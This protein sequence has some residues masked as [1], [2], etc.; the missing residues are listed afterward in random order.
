MSTAYYTHS[1]C[2]LH[3]MG[4]GHPECPRRL[5]AINDQLLSSGLD[6]A[7]MRMDA[8]LATLEQ[9]ERAHSTGYVIQL[10]DFLEQLQSSGESRHLD[11]DTVACPSTWRAAL[12]AAGAAVAATEA[13]VRGDVANAFCAVR[14]PGH[15]ATRD[16]TMGF[17]FFNNVAIAARHALDVL[18]LRRVAIVDFDVHHGNGTEDIIAGD[19]VL[20]AI[21][22]MD[23]EV[24]DGHPAQ[25]QDIQGMACR[26]RHVVE[27][28]KAH[29]LVA[30]G[31]VPGRPHG[32][33][34]IGHIAAHHGFGCGHC[35]S[36]RAQR[37]APGRRTGDRVGVE[38]ARL[39]A[40]LQLLEEVTQL[41]DIAGAVRPFD[42]FQRCQWRVHAHQCHVQP[43]AQQLVVDGIEPPRALGVAVPHVMQSAIGVCVVRGGHRQRWQV[44]GYGAAH[45]RPSARATPRPSDG[46]D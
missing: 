28:A 6:M 16:E 46:S 43:G 29:R 25:T 11:P 31:M 30:R 17:C 14:P 23:I 20:G 8:P 32:A 35:R 39:A 1:D 38:M 19:D 3:D 18:G 12:R 42:L 4:D 44:F 5:D 2:R 34:R 40:G 33:K 15:H 7:L 26:N 9:I 45:G 10:R 41:D 21:A 37:S 24:D 27:E 13:V 36:G 22:M